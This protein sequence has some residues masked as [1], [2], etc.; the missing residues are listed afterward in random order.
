M[1]DDTERSVASAGSVAIGKAQ[2]TGYDEWY[3]P[4]YQCP[5]CDQNYIARCFCYCPNCGVK[6]EWQP[7]ARPEP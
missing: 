4:W 6:L 1:S 7:H 2:D 3:C 5:K